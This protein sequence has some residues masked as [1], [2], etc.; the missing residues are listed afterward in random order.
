MKPRPPAFAFAA[1]FLLL[2]AIAV[3]AAAEAANRHRAVGGWRVESVA[4]DDG[5]RIVRMT[6]TGA[7]YSLHYETWYW[8]GNARVYRRAAAVRG[9]CGHEG[10][11][12]LDGA[13][14]PS[15]REVRAALAARL[16][17]C[18]APAREVRAALEGFGGAFA[19]AY[20]WGLEA[21]A[22]TAAEA[23][24]IANYGAEPAA[25]R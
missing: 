16:A 23:A 8:R 19:L 3:G 6:R 18:D 14:D 13:A 7:G 21:E 24:A 2:A 5:G 22:A 4:E 25:P 20:A 1:A 15:A 10:E 9:D 17:W 12:G 11:E